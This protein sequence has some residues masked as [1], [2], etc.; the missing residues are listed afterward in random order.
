MS[1]GVIA[2]HLR[3]FGSSAAFDINRFPGHTLVLSDL[4]NFHLLL[5]AVP[6]FFLVS[7]FLFFA[8]AKR[9]QRYFRQRLKKLVGLYFFWTGLWLLVC[10]KLYGFFFVLKKIIENAVIFAVTGGYS[11][12]YFFFSL[13]ILTCV[14]YAVLKVSRF[15]LWFL[16]FLS[17]ALL[18]GL[19]FVAR[20][21]QTLHCLVAFWNPLN[22]L[23]YVFISALVFEYRPGSGRCAPTG[24]HSNSHASATVVGCV[25]GASTFRQKPSASP[26]PGRLGIIVHAK[27][28]KIGIVVLFLLLTVFLAAWIEWQWFW[29]I[30]NFQYNDFAI[31]AYTRVSVVGSATLVFLAAFLVRRPPP[32]WIKILSNYSM[33]LYCLHGFVFL[34]FLKFIGAQIHPAGRLFVFALTVAISLSATACLR[35]TPIKKLL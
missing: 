31:P 13:I 32:R 22:F 23:P 9:N 11:L 14:S 21:V 28:N 16:A 30:H 17:A 2:W 35:R 33:G 4:I 5:L 24:V 8:K 27:W 18:G 26:S 1:L 25:E 29:G 19:A 20:E 10:G 34:F 15:A 7:L 12:Y 3:V 6:V